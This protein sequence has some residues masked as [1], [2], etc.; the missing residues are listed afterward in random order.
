MGKLFRVRGQ[1]EMTP[2]LQFIFNSFLLLLL[3]VAVLVFV[4]YVVHRG[5][6]LLNIVKFNRSMRHIDK[7]P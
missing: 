1:L 7:D 4:I 5:V 2:L 6:R 3:I